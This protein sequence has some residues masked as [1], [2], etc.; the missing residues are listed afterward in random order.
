MSLGPDNTVCK[1]E[2]VEAMRTRLNADGLPGS[3][4]DEPSVNK[5]LAALGEAVFRIAT[6]HAATASSAAADAAYWQWVAAVTAWL[7]QLRAWQTGVT[8]AFT[9]W[10][11]TQPAEVALKT[12]LLAVPVGGPPPPAAP[13]TLSGR[14]V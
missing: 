7:G 6:V 2:F 8:A 1:T 3:N 13:A 10:T 14:I 4:V 12:A 9:A 11:P 5:N